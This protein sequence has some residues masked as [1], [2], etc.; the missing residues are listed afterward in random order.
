MK[1]R[2]WEVWIKIEDMKIRS[3]ENKKLVRLEKGSEITNDK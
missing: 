2:S 3:Y 1:I